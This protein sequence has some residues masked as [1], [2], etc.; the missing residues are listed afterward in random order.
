MKT[1]MSRSGLALLAALLC[2]ALPS[3]LR[4]GDTP[5]PLFLAGG[6]LSH[7]ALMERR[8]VVYRNQGMAGDALAIL[9]AHGLTCVRLRLWTASEAD[10][11]KD[12]YN[13]GNTLAYTVALAKRVKRAGLL[14]L[15]DFHYSDSWADPAHQARPAAWDGLTFDQVEERMYAYNRDAIAAFRSADALPDYVQIGNETPM[16]FAWPD[17]KVDQPAKW[18]LLARLVAAADRGIAEAAGARKPKT[19]IHL[20]RGGDW[21]TTQWFFDELI[22]K[23]HA[24]FDIIGQSYYP[25]WHGDFAKLRTCLEKCVERYGKPVIVAETAFPWVTN[26]RDGSDA[27]LIN[28]LAAGPDG[29]ARFAT[30]LGA[31][32]AALPEH[33][34]LGIFWWGAEFNA[35][36]GFNFDGFENRSF[37]DRD[38]NVL[39]VVDALGALVRVAR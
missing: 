3:P 32:L 2:G 21:G 22:L 25:F 16:G 31:I 19:I 4:A 30:E 5:A 27:K 11:G 13:K 10:A 38:G 18:A 14:F 6:D 7:L 36:G 39:P 17:G 1:V 12:P 28:G 34:G 26:G 8:G 24:R 29:Q 20:D 9:K 23:Q 37:W 33:K 15:L 35:A